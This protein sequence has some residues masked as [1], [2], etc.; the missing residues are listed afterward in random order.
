MSMAYDTETLHAIGALG[1]IQR[2][3]GDALQAILEAAARANGLADQTDWRADAASRFRAA[4]DAWCGDVAG[5]ADHVE[6]AREEVSRASARLEL[7]ASSP[8]R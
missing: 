3:L 2:Q 1:E 8:A 4:S 7:L 5:L 6:A